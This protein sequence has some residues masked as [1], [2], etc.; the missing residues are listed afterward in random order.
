[1]L[2]FYQRLANLFARYC[3]AHLNVVAR[4]IPLV[5]QTGAT[6]GFID[7]VSL[8]GQRLIIEGWADAA[9]VTVHHA[10]QKQGVAPNLPRQDVHAA[11]P[12]VAQ[13]AP[14]FAVDF[15]FGSGPV[16]VTLALGGMHLVYQ[17][18]PPNSTAIGRARRALALPFLRDMARALPTV[19]WWFATKDP[20]CR[21]RFKHHL[22][23]VTPANARAM[24]PLL[25]LADSL[26]AMAPKQRMA[27]CARLHPAALGHRSITI[28]LPIYNA[29]DVL[30]EALDR[31]LRHTDLPWRLIMIDD[32]SPDPAMRLFLRAWVAKQKIRFPGRITLLENN[33]NHGFIH[34]VNAGLALAI[35]HGDHVVLLNSDAFVPQGW[36][37]RLM[38]PFLAHDRVAT[39]TPMSND[40]EI[41]TAPVICQRRDLHPKEADQIDMA[42][43]TL[44]PDAALTDAPTGVG[45]CMAM[46]IDYLRQIPRLDTSFGRGYGEEVDWCQKA[47]A[48]GGRHLG[49][50]NLFVEHRGGTSFGSAEKQ[51]LVPRNNEIISKRYPN[52]DADVQAFMA[53]DP[54]TAPRLA[55]AIAWAAERTK[56]AIPI[57]LA[58]N[59]GGGAEDYLTHRISRDMPEPAVVL[60]VGTTLRWQLELHCTDG[61]TRGCTDDFALIQRMLDPVKHRHIVYSCGVGD[62]DP[63]AL[64][65]LLL[66]LKRG[67]QDQIEI[68]FHD[69][70][71]ISPSY[72]L[73]N[74]SGQFPGLPDAGSIEPA[75][76]ARRPD[77]ASA[78]LQDWQAQWGALVTKATHLTAFCKSSATLIAGA[79]PKAR[80]KLRVVPHR[81]LLDLPRLPARS[82]GQRPVIG[83]L[84]NI[85]YHKGASVLRDLSQMLDRT[86]AAKLVVLGQIDP[87]FPLAASAQV[88]GGYA[89]PDIP[90]LVARY[91]IT[92]WLIPSIWPETFSYTTHEA[93]ATGLPVWCFDLGAQAS[94]VRTSALSGGVIP[95]PD[96]LPDLD[97]LYAAILHLSPRSESAAA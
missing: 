35:D 88:H 31:I 30:P 90:A 41:F 56:R 89:R 23:L 52:Y 7:R 38:R 54:L 57:Y 11:Y 61:V 40:A 2:M 71:P 49:L 34:S 95:I 25:F 69:Y 28:I 24:Q 76:T 55:L 48:L 4:G 73:L 10:D 81:V 37:T 50:A 65:A 9:T 1:M 78:T 19:L 15:A 62:P 97:A 68:L 53:A 91:G 14:G 63:V 12:D 60:R 44:H 80:T 42:A 51:K 33:K 79:Y 29:L 26:A 86:A 66:A 46:S 17:I 45:F 87:A 47:R 32:A 93:I 43:S 8:R 16:T 85:G 20:A 6:L 94:A 3:A 13:L 36:A 92:D 75:H 72:T 74:G 82:A 39:V 83:V 27:E 64:P 22:R 96:G 77:G 21:T 18:E 84:G 70:F 58:H 67:D 5:G 59:L